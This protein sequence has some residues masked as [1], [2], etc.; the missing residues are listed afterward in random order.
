MP[1]MLAKDISRN[2][3]GRYGSDNSLQSSSSKIVTSVYK[4]SLRFPS[5]WSTKKQ[6]LWNVL[7]STAFAGL[8]T[9]D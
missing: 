4:V 8:P 2:L 6:K 7:T 9:S 1:M 3:P 5:C